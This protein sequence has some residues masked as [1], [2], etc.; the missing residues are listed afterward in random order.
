MTDVGPALELYGTRGCPY[1]AEVR[2]QLQWSRVAFAE[3]DVETDG[4]ARA[5][6]LTLTGGRAAVPVLVEDGRVKEI[7]WHGRTCSFD[8]S[9][10]P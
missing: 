9:Q 7:G 8:A 3:Y 1:T 6:L 10:P 5:R 4:D 2:E